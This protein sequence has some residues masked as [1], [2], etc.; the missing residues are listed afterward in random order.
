MKLSLIMIPAL[1]AVGIGAV[2]QAPKAVL[3]TYPDNT[4]DSVVTEA[5]NMIKINGGTITHQYT[6]FKGFAAQG[7]AELF[8]TVQAWTSSSYPATIEEDQVVTANGDV[9][10]N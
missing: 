4:P 2:A 9:S 6:L 7:P 8:D 1:L 5:M 10:A 3:F